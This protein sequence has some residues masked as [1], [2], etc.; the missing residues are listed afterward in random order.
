MLYSR[1]APSAAATN[2]PWNVSR[3]PMAVAANVLTNSTNSGTWAPPPM[4][5]KASS[6]HH[7]DIASS[8]GTYASG[9]AF[10]S[11]PGSSSTAPGSS[12]GDSP[13]LL[14]S[15]DLKTTAKQF[16]PDTD[17]KSTAREFVPSFP[18]TSQPGPASQTAQSSVGFSDFFL[19]IAGTGA[20]PLSQPFSGL[21]DPSTTMPES[22]TPPSLDAVW[23]PPSP[24]DGDPATITSMLP[25]KSKSRSML[26]GLG[27]NDVDGLDELLDDDDAA[28]LDE[29]IHSGETP[30]SSAP[31]GMLSG[32][33]GGLWGGF[34][35][36]L[37]GFGGIPAS[38]SEPSW[39]KDHHPDDDGFLMESFAT[40]L[41]SADTLVTDEDDDHNE[42][43][44]IHT[45]QVDLA[46]WDAVADGIGTT[47]TPT[48][49]SAR[50]A[51][52]WGAGLLESAGTPDA[53]WGESKSSSLWE[54]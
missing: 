37:G 52:A 43:L 19:D 29:A 45:A 50:V 28:V 6:E 18:M 36:G 34:G 9:A 44:Q 35:G 33:G 22:T 21:P 42:S 13:A 16:V 32:A 46:A 7:P 1:T 51:A 49:V 15:T 41:A 23:L 27:L 2:A 30:A 10:G 40:T 48:G 25:Q 14:G 26:W 3:P 53:V 31:L 11:L 39:D 24:S 38:L 54:F 47:P 12:P 20:E 5:A 4:M 17:L 8:G